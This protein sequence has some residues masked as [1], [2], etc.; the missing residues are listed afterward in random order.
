MVRDEIET[1]EKPVSVV[2]RDEALR[3]S[4]KIG[5]GSGYEDELRETMQFWCLIVKTFGEIPE[6]MKDDCSSCAI[7]LDLKDEDTK[8]K[9]EGLK[10]SVRRYEDSKKKG[11][12]ENVCLMNMDGYI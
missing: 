7:F 4:I 3:L 8:R 10:I 2:D 11:S 12:S 6:S 5:N 9:F 1:F